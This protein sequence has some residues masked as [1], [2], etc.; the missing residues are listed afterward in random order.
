LLQNEKGCCAKQGAIQ[1]L[2]K[3]DIVRVVFGFDWGTMSDNYVLIYE[4][5]AKILKE[6]EETTGVK[7]I[8]SMLGGRDGSIYCDICSQINSADIALFDVSSHNVNVAFELGL[9]LGTGAYVFALR[10]QHQKRSKRSF[11]DLNGILEYRFSRRLAVLK[12]ETN[13]EQSLRAKLKK[14]TTGKKKS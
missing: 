8:F 13:F 1:S 2:Q 4:Y 5:V 3:D 7:G 11:S 12:F 14:I 6:M 10:S 9:A